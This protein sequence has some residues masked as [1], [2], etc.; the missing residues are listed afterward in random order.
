MNQDMERLIEELSARCEKIGL[1]MRQS[2]V[3]IA[4]QE[5]QPENEANIMLA[6]DNEL[7]QKMLDGDVNVV[8]FG[9]FT[10]NEVAF[11]E[12][13]QNPQKFEVDTTFQTLV[14]SEEEIIKEKLREKLKNSEDLLDLLDDEDEEE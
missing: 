8:I 2:M 12:R 6:S 10:V 5:E 1:Y 4:G 3:T 7:K 11:S 13:V 14:P 9:L